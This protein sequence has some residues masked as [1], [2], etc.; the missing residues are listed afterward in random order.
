MYSNFNQSHFTFL[1]DS[2]D[3]NALEFLKN[4]TDKFKALKT[5]WY[6]RK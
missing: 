4:L 1:T 2:T 6:N 3:L 5:F